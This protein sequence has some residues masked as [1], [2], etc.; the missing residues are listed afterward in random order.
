M[1]TLALPSSVIEVLEYIDA[2]GRSPYAR[3]FGR[4]PAQAAAKVAVAVTRMSHG[5]LSNVKSVGEGVLEYRIDWGPGYRI[6]LG[7][8]GA[9]L[10]VLLGGG[11]K[12]GQQDDIGRARTCWKDY[13][14]RKKQER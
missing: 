3:W 10:I 7:R 12:G 5:N 6:Y 14:K 11:T 4:L 1:V 13:Q 9:K 2:R 8:D